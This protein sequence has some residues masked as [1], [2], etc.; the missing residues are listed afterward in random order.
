MDRTS[1]GKDALRAKGKWWADNH[2][3]TRFE[4]EGPYVNEDRFT[5]RFRMTVVVKASRQ[6]ME[7]DEHAL[8]TVKDGKIVEEVY[9]YGG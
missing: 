8:Y 9:F 2:E 1:R 4:V 5:C 7:L 3:T 6:T